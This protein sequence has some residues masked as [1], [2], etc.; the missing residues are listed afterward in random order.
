MPA[1][2]L[3]R[4]ASRPAARRA[5]SPDTLEPMYASIG[6]GIPEGDA[7]TFEPKY[8]GIRVLAHVSRRG[9]RL[10]TRNLKD[11]AAQFPEVVAAL[12]KL[13]AKSDGPLILDG[14]IV[15]L[16][17]DEPARFQALQTRMHVKAASDVARHSADTPAALVAFDLLRDGGDV[18]LRD[19]W[20]ERR[21]RLERRLRGKLPRGLLLGDSESGDGAKMLEQARKAG[22]E[23]I[24]AKRTSALYYPGKRSEDWLKLKVE[25]RQ[26]FVVGG[27][28][29]PRNTREHIGALL[30]GYYDGDR[31][32]YVGHMGGG[33]TRAGLETMHRKL[34]PL[35]RKTSPF[36]VPPKTNEPAHWAKPK[37]VVEVKFSEMTADGR[38]RQPIYVGTRDDKDAREVTLEGV[39]VQRADRGGARPRRLRSRPGGRAGARAGDLGSR[40]QVN[41][42]SGRVRRRENESGA[43]A[44]AKKATTRARKAAGRK[45]AKTAKSTK[46]AKRAASGDVVRQIDAI[47]EAGGGGTLRLPGRRTLEVTSLDK[48]FFPKTGHTKGDVMRYYAQVAPALLPL[49]KDRP[50]VFKRF[51]N[52]VGGPSFFQ[53]NAPEDVPAGVRVETIHNDQGEAQRRFIGGDLATLLYS[54]QIGNISVDPWHERVKTLDYADYMIL[55][56]D[57]GDKA[58]FRRVVQVARWVKEALD[59]YGLEGAAKTSGSTGI[60]IYVPLPPRTTDETSRLVGEIIATQVAAAHPREA[61]VE[62]S[63]KARAADQVYVDYLQNIK[64]KTVA[65]A[66]AVRAKPLATVSTPLAWDELT[67]DLDATA[68]TI[69]TVPER[70]ARVGD[71][72]G[73]GMRVRNSLAKLTT[74][75]G[76]RRR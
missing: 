63:V 33:F 53:Q 48:V 7:W 22:W 30:L 31:F 72:W 15:A 54:V 62:R 16:D 38:L 45:T 36:E 14:E 67:D 34:A 18:L 50:L 6:T 39:S 58:S 69:D 21:A 44:M 52:G 8:D 2:R 17:G 49:V 71:L 10:V 35:E 66:Y 24:I 73:P 65:A 32:V 51:P 55:D 60:H 1:E 68:F 64:A 76:S 70:L 74:K 28:T 13:A 75:T 19:P 4:P 26:E 40:P 5:L 3:T 20:T 11:K 47:A 42:S 9:V 12:E 25:F 61:T 56:L 29:E 43:D 46:T 23:G 27:W 41:E 37:V 57:P 59:E